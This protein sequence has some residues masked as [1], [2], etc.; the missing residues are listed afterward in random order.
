MYVQQ[1]Q[2]YDKMSQFLHN[3]NDNKTKAIA[4]LRDFYEN[5]PAKNLESDKAQ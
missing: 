5:S 3:N 1:W 4:I 2:R